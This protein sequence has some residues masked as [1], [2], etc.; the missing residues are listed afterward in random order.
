MWKRAREGEMSVL[1]VCTVA[2]VLGS[3]T[4]QACLSC[5]TYL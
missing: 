1:G 5:V 4:L 2:V 3:T